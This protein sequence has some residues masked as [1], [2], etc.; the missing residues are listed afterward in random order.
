[1]VLD[2][3]TDIGVPRPTILRSDL[4][5]RAVVVIPVYNH[6][7][8]VA[9][10]LSRTARLNIEIVV[11]DDGSTDETPRV[12]ADWCRANP[13]ERA[14]VLTHRVNRGKAAALQT[15]F[16]HAGALGATHAVTIDADGQLDP[17][18]IPRL[19]EEATRHPQ[20]LIL[21]Q[22]PDRVDGC[23]RR[24]AIGRGYAS[25]AVLAQ[26]GIRLGDTQCG[27]RV[28]PLE[29]L[30]AIRCRAGRYAFEAEAITRAA[31]AGYEV[32]AMPVNC[33]Y[34]SAAERVSHWKPWRDSVRQG[35]VHLRL[36]GVALVP[37]PWR[38]GGMSDRSSAPAPRHRRLLGWLNPVRSWR[39]VREEA[40]GDLELASGLALGAWIGSL[41]FFGLHTLM[42]V[43]VAWRLHQHPAAVVLGSQVSVPP[44]GVVLAAGS[45]VVGHFM[46]TGG[47]I[48][49]D[50]SSLTWASAWRIPLQGL[51][52]WL[53]GSIVV[54]AVVA[55]MAYAL[56]L[57]VARQ[58]RRATQAADKG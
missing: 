32:R 10:V 21:G 19:L 20:A 41:P 3:E 55:G 8:G 26:T 31:W 5:V 18:D 57:W 33:R 40:I 54:G 22:R 11:V 52:E 49:V 24:C 35:G 9:R 23:P 45:M 17:E 34:F 53:L 46:L 51:A 36:V 42:S 47:M 37:W 7:G 30:R 2:A 43:Y 44:L 6:A 12:L 13:G 48:H 1:M 16:K 14:V 38:R 15:G 56:G 4:G 25:L 27:L 29:L 39:Q 50:T 28:Y 58:M